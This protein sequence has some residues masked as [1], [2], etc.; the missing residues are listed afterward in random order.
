[1]VFG[2]DQEMNG[3]KNPNYKDGRW[4][5]QNVV[6]KVCGTIFYKA[7][8]RFS[9]TCMTCSNRAKLKEINSSGKNKHIGKDNHF[10]EDGESKRG[11]FPCPECGEDRICK[12]KYG[13][14]LCKKCYVKIVG[15]WIAGKKHTLETKKKQRIKAIERIEKQKLN[16][17]PLTPCIGKHETHVLDV[18]EYCFGYPITRQKRVAGYFLDGYCGMLNIAV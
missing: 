9:G 1:M 6:C 13:Y 18:L 16:G 4:I 3:E 17:L 15:S 7:P 14:K 12:K 8:N 10:W 5:K 11:N 2:K